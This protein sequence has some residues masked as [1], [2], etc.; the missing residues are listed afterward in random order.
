MGWKST[1]IM[2]RMRLF[3]CVR[4]F[5]ASQSAD[6]FFKILLVLET[7]G[8]MLKCVYRIY[9]FLEKY[10]NKKII[11]VMGDCISLSFHIFK[12]TK[13]GREFRKSD[14]GAYSNDEINFDPYWSIVRRHLRSLQPV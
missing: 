12:F 8:T 3:N 2:G 11:H 1:D 14:S 9:A 4:L 6:C 5:T 7:I 10:Q 13:L